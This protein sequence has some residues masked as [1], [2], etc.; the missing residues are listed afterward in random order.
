MGPASLVAYSIIRNHNKETFRVE[1]PWFTYTGINK[2]NMRL[3]RLSSHVYI[4]TMNM[5]SQ[6]FA[7]IMWQM[8]LCYPILDPSQIVFRKMLTFNHVRTWGL[9]Q[10]SF[11]WVDLITTIRL[12]EISILRGFAYQSHLRTNL[13]GVI[14]FWNGLSHL[15]TQRKIVLINKVESYVRCVFILFALLCFSTDVAG[16]RREISG[17]F[18]AAHRTEPAW[19]IS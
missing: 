14:S 3:E 10:F 12:S 4:I 9:F 6:T 8:L 13:A 16:R 2:Y 11:L 18:P 7:Y 17:W 5:K 1:P 15:K 19:E